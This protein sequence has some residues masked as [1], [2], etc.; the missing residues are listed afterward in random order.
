MV[1]EREMNSKCTE[2]FAV[3]SG[4]EGVLPRSV[5]VLKNLNGRNLLG[6]KKQTTVTKKIT[7]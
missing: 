7:Y 2:N 1:A 6:I 4:A 3:Q 5:N